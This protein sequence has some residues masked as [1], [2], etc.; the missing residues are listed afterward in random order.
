MCC[1]HQ[2]WSAGWER[3]KWCE[4]GEHC[5]LTRFPQY[6]WARRS[7][8]GNVVVHVPIGIMTPMGGTITTRPEISISYF[9]KYMQ[10]ARIS[11]LDSQR[12]IFEDLQDM[13]AELEGFK[14]QDGCFQQYDHAQAVIDLDL[15]ASGED[16]AE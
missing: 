11:D 10:F 2:E 14:G 3:K 4:N 13:M 7:L 5:F 1:E 12:K 15:R 16:S 6:L 8:L 9:D